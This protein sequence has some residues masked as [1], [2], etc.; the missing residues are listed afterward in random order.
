MGGFHQSSF[1][2]NSSN[3]SAGVSSI[4]LPEDPT[5]SNSSEQGRNT[6]S[7]LQNNSNSSLM[8]GG[9]SER[10][11]HRLGVRFDLDNNEH[12]QHPGP[13]SQSGLTGPTASHGRQLS[14]QLY[15][16]LAGNLKKVGSL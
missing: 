12:N 10:T 6:S 15:R 1:P 4:H 3:T 7:S 8:T 2:Q 14:M 13:N 16:D 9:S 5:A 11:R